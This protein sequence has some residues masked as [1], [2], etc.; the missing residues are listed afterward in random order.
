[1]NKNNISHGDIK[2]SQILSW[3]FSTVTIIPMFILLFFDFSFMALFI[4]LLALTII[5]LSQYYNSNAWNIWYEGDKLFFENIYKTNK[6]D[7]D[8][9]KKI[10][11]NGFLGFFY[12]IHLNNGEI[13]RFR[14]NPLDDLSLFF[15]NDKYIHVNKMNEKIKDYIRTQKG[16]ILLD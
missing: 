12:S 1:M 8:L 10:E 13:F 4:T 3:L 2:V 15:N 7:I 5:I 6:R 16:H 14:I 11:Q 9:F